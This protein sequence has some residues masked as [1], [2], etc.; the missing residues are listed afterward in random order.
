MGVEI[1]LRPDTKPE[2]L[3][4]IGAQAVLA[5]VFV[6]QN[7]LRLAEVSDLLSGTGE[8]LLLNAGGPATV[9]ALGEIKRAGDAV[10]RI[11]ESF[12]EAERALMDAVKILTGE[13]DSA[14]N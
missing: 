2:V 6:G 13:K 3:N 1:Q 5:H 8:Q 11:L 4:V 14:D 9:P 7:S 12:N 10:K